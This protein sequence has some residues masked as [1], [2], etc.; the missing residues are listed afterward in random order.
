MIFAVTRYRYL[1]RP[2]KQEEPAPS[3]KL[4]GMGDAV[5]LVAKPAAGVIDLALGTELRNCQPC[6]GPGG[7]QERMNAALPFGH[8]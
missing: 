8:V 1:V 4:M 5:A 3:R 2:T 7:R 6:I